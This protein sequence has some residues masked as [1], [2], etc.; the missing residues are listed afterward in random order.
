LTGVEAVINSHPLVYV[1]ED[2][3]SR[4]ALTASHFLLLHSNH[5]IPDLTEDADPEFN[6]TGIVFSSDQP[7]EV[8][9]EAFESILDYLVTNNPT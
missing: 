9:M 5:V 7:W 4:I 1:D 6:V 3:N 2:I 8:W